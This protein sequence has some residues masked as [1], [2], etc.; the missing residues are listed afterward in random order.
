MKYWAQFYELR[1]GSYVEPCGDRQL[2]FL[3]G[4]L[5]RANMEAIAAE[6]CL[7][8]KYDGWRIARGNHLLTPFYLNAA[9]KTVNN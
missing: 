7:K 9:V 6:Q 4:R 8:R 1:S 3:D 2:V 5:S